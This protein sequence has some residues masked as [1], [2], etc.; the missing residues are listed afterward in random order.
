[1]GGTG[2]DLQAGSIKITVRLFDGQNTGQIKRV[3]RLKILY[4]VLIKP[5]QL[6]KEVL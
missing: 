4:E 6:L 2:D 5:L 3:F 1:M